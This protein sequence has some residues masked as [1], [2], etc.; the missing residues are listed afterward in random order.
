MVHSL[1]SNEISGAGAKALADALAMHE[2]LE[3]LK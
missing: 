3:L 1:S 2:S